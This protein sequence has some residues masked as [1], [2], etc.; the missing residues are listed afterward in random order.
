MREALYPLPRVSFYYHEEG[1]V[2][3]L[4]GIAGTKICR[5]CFTPV[6]DGVARFIRDS[7]MAAI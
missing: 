4:A 1:I 5:L 2:R 7:E 3:D 6:R